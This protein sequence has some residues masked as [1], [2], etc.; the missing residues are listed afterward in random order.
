MSTNL[1]LEIALACGLVAVL[2]GFIQRAWILKQDAG[3]ARMQEIAAAIQQGAAAYLARQYRTIAIVGVVLAI[4]IFCF[5]GDSGSQRML[6]AGGYVLG[7]FL[8][9]ACGFIGMNVSVRANVRTAQAAT[10]GI[11]P[12]LDVA[13]KGGAIT[14]MLVVGLGLLGVGLFLM[15]LLSGATEPVT[16][17]TLKPLLGFAFGSSLISIFA[18]L[19]GGIFTKGADVGADLVGKVEAGIPEDDPR[20]PAVI[21][22]NVG[23]NVGDCAGMAAD[24]FETYAVTLIATMT[25]GVLVLGGATMSAVVYPLLMGG[26]SIV[27]SIIGCG[28]VKAS[29]DMKNV[30]PALYKG[31]AVAGVLSLIAFYFVTKAVMADDVLAGGNTVMRLFGACA[32]GLVLT[33]ALVS[34]H[35]V[36]HRHAV[37]ARCSTSPRPP[38]PA[39]A[40]TS[41]PAWACR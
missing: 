5:I 18:R 36:L 1:A 2:Y 26:V 4:L 12:A 33:G 41:S 11:G 23:D 19:G 31:L 6:T 10:K 32:V 22:D 27:A 7:A 9:G 14:G 35:R 40:P 25:L 20:N 21:A 16:A 17:A 30:M 24:L 8:S 3:N 29:P 34:G 37:R 15:F 28:F 39:T 38:P 13:F